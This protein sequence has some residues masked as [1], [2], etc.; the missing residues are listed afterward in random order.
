TDIKFLLSRRYPS[1]PVVAMRN[2]SFLPMEL[3]GVEPVRVKRITDE[4]RAMVCQKSSLNPSDYR[5]SIKDVRNNTEKQYFEKDPFIDAWNLQID[6]KMHITSARIIDPPKIIYNSGYQ[7][8]PQNCSTPSVWNNTN[9]EF[10]H[11]ASFPSVWAMINLSLTMIEQSCEEFYDNLRNVANERGM[12][13]PP[14]VIY[15]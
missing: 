12:H 6:P 8:S 9:T 13:C 4:Q 1:L 10:Y 2:G 7:I 11:P 15:Q 3:L 5:E 14:P